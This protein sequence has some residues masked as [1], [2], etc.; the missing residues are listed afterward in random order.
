M[1]VKYETITLHQLD[2]MKHAIGL[3]QAKPKR[4]KYTA[5]RN[6][7]CSS[8]TNTD[9]DTLVSCGLATFRVGDPAIHPSSV[10]YHV[11]EAGMRLIGSVLG[12]K[13]V[14]GD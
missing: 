12:F 13:I 5:Y 8:G 14:E 11:S 7:Y 4:G 3:D 2:L 10:F 9:W 6:Y 1:K